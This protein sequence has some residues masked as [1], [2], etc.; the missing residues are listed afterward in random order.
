MDGV[1]LSCLQFLTSGVICL[2]LA[3]L[4]EHPSWNALFAGIVPVLYAGVLSSG[5]G[6]TLQVVG[7][8]K[9][10][11]NSGIPAFEHGICFFRAGRL[12]DSGTEAFG[13]GAFGLRTHVCSG[14]LRTASG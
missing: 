5:V 1:K 11:A 10:G 14:D 9:S 7:Q 2:V 8:K 3:F 4:T 12:G 13:E 6:Y